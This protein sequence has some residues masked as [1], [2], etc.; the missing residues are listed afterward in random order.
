MATSEGGVT[1]SDTTEASE[2]G[3]II[4]T[5]DVS[6]ELG[7]EGTIAG[8]GKIVGISEVNASA[9]DP[10]YG[11]KLEWTNLNDTSKSWTTCHTVHLVFIG[12]LLP[13][14]VCGG[15]NFGVAVGI[16][17]EEDPPTM[18]DFPIPLAGNNFFIILI[19]TFANYIVSNNIQLF[20]VLNGIVAPLDPAVVS[21]WPQPNTA[22]F[23][24]MQPCELILSPRNEPDKLLLERL[25]D[26]LLRAGMWI[27]IAEIIFWPL[28]T[29]L[30][31]GLYG[32]SG[33]NSYPQPQWISAIFGAVLSVVF[34]PFWQLS[35]Y[36]TMGQRLLDEKD[37]FEKHGDCSIDP[38]ERPKSEYTFYGYLERKA[39]G[40]P[41]IDTS[42]TAAHAQSNY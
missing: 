27:F 40:D 24:W 9:Q 28:I 34:M 12:C 5:E 10:A 11:I 4:A 25:L 15:A 26:S 3:P 7:E 39:L 2:S 38:G 17:K 35:C 36:V 41:A 33:Y 20:D 29:V 16:F 13:T 37:S 42:A 22:L 1:H 8:D 21:W 23:W 31:Y 30:L 6:I 19:Q 18:W 32:N 14:L